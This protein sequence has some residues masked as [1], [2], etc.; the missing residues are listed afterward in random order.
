[1]P[2]TST[3]VPSP[4]SVTEQVP[5]AQFTPGSPAPSPAEPLAGVSV[6][7]VPPAG[8]D[9]GSPVPEHPAVGASSTPPASTPAARRGVRVRAMTQ[10]RS[11]GRG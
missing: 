3:V 2:S 5:S 7:V 11:V 9:E 8:A 1:M 10:A 4:D 6:R